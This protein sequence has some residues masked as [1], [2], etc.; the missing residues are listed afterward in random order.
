MDAKPMSSDYNE[1]VSCWCLPGIRE[2]IPLVRKHIQAMQC[3][4][5]QRFEDTSRPFVVAEYGCATGYSSIETLSEIV[6]TVKSFNLKIPVTIYLNDLPSNHHEIAITTVT[7]GLFGPD[8]QLEEAYR[9]QVHV[10]LAPH[11]FT[12]AVHPSDFVDFGFSN[13]AAATLPNS[14]TPLTNCYFFASE[15]VLGTPGGQAWVE[16]FDSFLSK[17]MQARS[18]ELKPTGRFCMMTQCYSLVPDINRHHKAEE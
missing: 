15:A 14:P 17:F 2:S 18:Q 6:R 13:M 3:E 7:A 10:Y 9:D 4:E 5:P 11:D 16:A 1:T 12:K 8:S